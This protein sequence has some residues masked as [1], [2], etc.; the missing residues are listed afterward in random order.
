MGILIFCSDLV[1]C[2]H[3]NQLGSSDQLRGI[4]D[5]CI[6]FV[7]YIQLQYCSCLDLL[8]ILN[9]SNSDSFIAT[10]HGYRTDRETSNPIY[11]IID[12]RIQKLNDSKLSPKIERTSRTRL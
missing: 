3:P 1:D 12:I 10:M 2:N 6:S 8:Y 7:H 4:P 9:Y 5:Y 11:I